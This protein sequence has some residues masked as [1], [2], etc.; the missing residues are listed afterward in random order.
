[1]VGPAWWR[2][3]METF[4]VLLALCA[5]NSPGTQR[6]VTR[7]FDVFFDL[8]LNKRLSEQSWGW[9][10]ETLSC[11]LWRHCNGDGL[12]G[13]PNLWAVIFLELSPCKTDFFRSYPGQMSARPHFTSI[14]HHNANAT[15]NSFYSHPNSIEQ[16]AIKFCTW[17]DSTCAM[18]KNLLRCH[19]QEW[20]DSE[21]NFPANL[22]KA[23]G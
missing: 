3:Q 15:E 9:W 12:Y 8:H 13:Y 11:S 5:G 21:T 10:F 18:C 6:P 14:F 16:M 23:L 7:S 17:H 20:G 1:M 4:S 19:N 22:K 2:R